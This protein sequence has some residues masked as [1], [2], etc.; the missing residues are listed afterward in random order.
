M[1]LELGE[2]HAQLYICNKADKL[3]ECSKWCVH[4]NPHKRHEKRRYCTQWGE[5]G[6]VVDGQYITHKVRCVRYK[7]K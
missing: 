6:L 1:S 3:I 2:H 5:C 7:N 4:G